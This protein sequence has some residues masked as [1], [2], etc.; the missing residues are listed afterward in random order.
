MER[1]RILLADDNAELLDHL[2]QVL[3]C[4]WDVVA[5]CADGESALQACRQFNPEFVV[6][7]ISMKKMS[8]IEVARQLSKERRCPK[9]LFLT[10]HEEPEFICAAFAAGGGGY[11]VKSRMTLDLEPALGALK[12]GRIFVSPTLETTYTH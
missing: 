10:V 2:V 6:L 12:A 4:D 8:G 9:I 11:V 1:P 7:D 3:A 5:A